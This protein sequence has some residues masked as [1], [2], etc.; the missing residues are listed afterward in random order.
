[1]AGALAWALAWALAGAEKRAET[2]KNGSSTHPGAQAR[3][4]AFPLLA[5]SFLFRPLV[6][7][8][9]AAFTEAVRESRATVGQWMPWAHETYSITDALVS[10]K[11]N[12]GQ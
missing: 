7:G 10:F 11:D 1:M 4:D 2:D 8:D 5:G 6:Q 9:A 12:K 3:E